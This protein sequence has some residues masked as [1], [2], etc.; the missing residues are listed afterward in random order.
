MAKNGQKI[1][2][3]YIELG[4][5]INQLQ[6]DFDTAGKT[7]SQTVA[8]LNSENNRI[9]LKTDIDLSKL[10]G[11]GSALDKLK[12]K[13]QAINQQLDIQRQ[14]QSVL[15]AVYAGAQKNYGLDSG[16]TQR[17]GT[18]L[19]YQ[20]RSVAAL[21]AQMRTL[22]LQIEASGSAAQGFGSRMAAGLAAAQGGIHSLSGGFS[23]L[24]GKMAA[25]MAVT[26]TGAGLFNLT[27]NA[28]KSGESIY[29]LT[30]RLHTTTAEAAS[31]QRV[32]QFAGV[33]IHTVIPLF[34]R[35]DK[36]I[37]STG[38]AGNATTQ[39]MQ[40]FGVAL[41]D[42]SG[43]LLPLN[44]QLGQLAAGYKKAQENGQA[45]AFTA[46][47]L[48]A[49]GA[50]LIPILEQYQD[51]MEINARV[52][53]T[54]LLDPEEAHR[55]YI[56]WSAMKIE[57]SQMGNAVGAA[58]LPVAEEMMPEITEGLSEFVSSIQEN[59][60][61][62]KDTLE[63]WG[64]AAAVVAKGIGALGRLF[65]TVSDDMASWKWLANEHP[66]A[67]VWGAV[68][69]V[70]PALNEKLYGEEYKE[71]QDQQKEQRAQ[72]AQARE[73][74]QEAKRQEMEAKRQAAAAER[75]VQEQ[76]KADAQANQKIADMQYHATHNRLENEIYDIEQK[77][78]KSIAAGTSEA[79]AWKLAEAEKAEASRKFKEELE[80]ENEAIRNEIY[81]MTHNSYD[82]KLHSIAL[83]VKELQKKGIDPGL[84]ASYDDAARAK[85]QES[86]Q[87]TIDS[88]NAIYKSSFENRMEQIDKQ[89]KSWLDAGVSEVEAT[90]AAEYAKY[91]AASDIQASFS[92]K[93]NAY[94]QSDLENRLAAIEK[95][96]KAWIDKGISEVEATRL[97]EAE[98][99]DAVANANRSVLTS[100]REAFNAY[101]Y[102]G[103]TALRS[104]I[105]RKDKYDSSVTASDISGFQ[106]AQKSVIQ[107]LYGGSDAAVYGKIYEPAKQTADNTKG[108]LEYLRGTPDTKEREQAAGYG[109]SYTNSGKKITY[110]N[111][112]PA[113]ICQVGDAPR[114]WSQ[115]MA[116]LYP[117]G[118][119]RIQEQYKKLQQDVLAVRSPGQPANSVAVNVS[120]GTAVTE[121]SAAMVKLADTVADKITPVIHRA[122]GRNNYGYS[123]W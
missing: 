74:E 108:I 107:E 35:L 64:S 15:Q 40:R 16:L 6:L 27:E 62:I 78:K 86:L 100:Q 51:L 84:I 41:T 77:A 79:T 113:K 82:N 29:K 70:G 18:N 75:K 85:A 49:R 80:K 5:D 33:D 109:S 73:E 9:K 22:K 39:A 121:D 68:P 26:T 114:T 104:Y 31:L 52:K 11:T 118:N 90:R 102:G 97:A 56:E 55:V 37:G 20:Q 1:D 28:M 111:I 106:K 103:D 57:A 61:E 38:T 92:E 69:L 119:Q 87:S 45:E 4:L 54:G 8:R 32:F 112:G 17:A 13:Y 110:Y 43:A 72:E 36:Q 117:S 24:S 23:L 122:L 47:I 46:E 58:L 48:G 123:N 76:Q 53:T 71:Y 7:V 10:E 60:D 67:A 116:R 91:K 50:A 25:I 88:M 115:D 93:L 14:K 66:A 105:M 19:L 44:Q 96:K 99:A 94:T 21:E 120:I 34:A 65:K 95:E 30:Q 12:V 83:R 89:K 59:K 63:G 98:K 3:L 2:E 101:R 81:A 42:Q